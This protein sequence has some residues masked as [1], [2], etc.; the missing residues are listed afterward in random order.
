MH[1]GIPKQ[2]QTA[3]ALAYFNE[4]SSQCNFQLMIYFSLLNSDTD[5]ERTGMESQE[6]IIAS[7]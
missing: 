6:N 4:S 3:D 1:G 2:V 5:P 7:E